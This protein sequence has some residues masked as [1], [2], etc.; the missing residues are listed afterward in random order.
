M[1]TYMR[2]TKTYILKTAESV[3]SVLFFF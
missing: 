1:T 3:P 2:I